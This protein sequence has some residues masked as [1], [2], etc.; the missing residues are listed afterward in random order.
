MRD[1]HGRRDPAACRRRIRRARPAVSA[2][3][4]LRQ[5]GCRRRDAPAAPR[6][7]APRPRPPSRAVEM[8]ARAGRRT[9]RPASIVR[10]SVLTAL[11]S[12]VGAE[13]AAFAPLGDLRKQHRP[14]ASR[15]QRGARN[16]EVVERMLHA[17]DF[18][19]GLVALAGDQHDVAG[20]GAVERA[21]RSP[22]RD[23]AAL[24]RARDRAKPA[25][26]SATMASPSSLR[27]LSSVTMIAVGAALRRWRP[28]AD[29]CRDRGRR[30]SRTR[31]SGGRACARAGW[32]APVP[33]HRACARSRPRPAAGRARRRRGSCGRRPAQPRQ[34][35]GDLGRA[36][37]PS[38]RSAPATASRLSTLK[39]PSSGERDREC[40]S[41]SLQRE[42]QALRRQ[43]A[44][45]SARSAAPAAP[46]ELTP[47]A[48]H[49]GADAAEQLAAEC[50]VEIDH[51]RL[52]GRPGEQ[53]RLG[54]AVGV[55]GAVV[56]E[57]VAG[58]VGEHGDVEMRR[59]RR[60]PARAH[61][62][63]TSIATGWRPASRICASRRCTAITSG[64]V[65]SPATC[66]PYR[67]AP[68]VPMVPT[69]SPSQAQRLGDQLHGGGLAV[70]AGH[71]GHRQRLRRRVVEAVGQHAQLARAARSRRSRRPGSAAS[72]GA[73]GS[74]RIAATL[75]RP[76]L[77]DEAQAMRAAAGQRDEGI[78]RH[79]ASRL[80][81]AQAARSPD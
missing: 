28:S 10:V 2:H 52:Q 16:G 4:T 74:N 6:R 54:R 69:V 80:S 32:P 55:H 19:V 23:R 12:D 3:S 26:M 73:G 58:E 21:A 22:R 40:D 78:A 62:R 30:R 29:A 14:H 42:L 37:Q 45:C 43:A 70:G 24:R 76:R 9:A 36:F 47:I 48:L 25:R 49:A 67:P 53:P 33:A 15:L 44:T 79:A 35:R 63:T 5:V 46:R 34:H 31:R 17:G 1:D 39:R 20:A 56:V 75:G 71:A 50:V 13:Q 38:A 60:G 72:A 57:M 66:S 41:P 61:A 64:V 59:R 11:I 77:V 81:A 51:R 65:R 8:L 18:L 27:G 68:S 7:R